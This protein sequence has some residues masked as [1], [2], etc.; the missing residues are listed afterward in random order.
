MK[1]TNLMASIC[2]TAITQTSAVFADG[3]SKTAA[4]GDWTGAYVGLS[5]IKRDF[6]VAGLSFD[7]NG[8]GIHGGYLHDFGKVVLGAELS[9]DQTDYDVGASIGDANLDSNA[10]MLIAGF[11]AGK[12]LPYVTFGV[13]SLS[14]GSSV[15]AERTD[16]GNAYGF[17]IAYQAADNIRVGLEYRKLDI[18]SYDNLPVDFDTSSVNLR[19]TYNF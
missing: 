5:Y 10:L 4:D 13:S 2:L 19:V 18:S 11:D 8:F 6:D 15:A 17:G 12:L 14:N 3:G 16:N 9:I 1:I 7:G